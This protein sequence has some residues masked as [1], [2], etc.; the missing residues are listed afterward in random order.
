[1]TADLIFVMLLVDLEIFPPRV[2]FRVIKSSLNQNNSNEEK[3]Y[4]ASAVGGCED[5]VGGGL[6]FPDR[7]DAILEGDEWDLIQQSCSYE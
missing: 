3:L 7:K 2:F 5:A 1:M 6:A 4:I